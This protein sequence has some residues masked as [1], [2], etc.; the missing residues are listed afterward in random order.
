LV[1]VE[2]LLDQGHHLAVACLTGAQNCFAG[3]VK[4]INPQG[5]QVAAGLLLQL[6]YSTVPQPISTEIR[7]LQ[8]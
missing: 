7:C 6:E 1:Q 8:R 2:H 5:L 4:A 3:E